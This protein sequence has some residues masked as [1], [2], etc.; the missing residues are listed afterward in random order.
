MKSHHDV[1]RQ[2]TDRQTVVHLDNGLLV[3]KETSSQAMTRH[4]GS[5]QTL[6]R[7]EKPI[8]KGYT[9]WEPFGRRRECGDGEKSGVPGGE[10]WELRA[11]RAVERLC[12]TLHGGHMALYACPNPQK[13]RPQVNPLVSCGLWVMTVGPSRLVTCH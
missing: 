7:G 12:G 1:L 8:W 13:A 2:G 5:L 9:V 3:L 11:L 10:G 6:T 4:G